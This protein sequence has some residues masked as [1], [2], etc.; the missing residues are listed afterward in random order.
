MSV[1][2]ITIVAHSPYFPI[3][4]YLTRCEAKRLPNHGYHPRKTAYLVRFAG[5][6]GVLALARQVAASEGVFNAWGGSSDLPSASVLGYRF[7]SALA[8]YEAR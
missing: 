8:G 1:R 6:L 4:E 2:R 3:G 7:S 5:E